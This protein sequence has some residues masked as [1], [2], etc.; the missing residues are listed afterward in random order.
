MQSKTTSKNLNKQKN[1]IY[2]IVTIF[3]LHSK[4]LFKKILQ[5]QKNSK[6]DYVFSH[7][8]HLP[9]NNDNHFLFSPW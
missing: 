3:S 7:S 8:P 1:N 6:T 9:L 2:A 4:I 5:K